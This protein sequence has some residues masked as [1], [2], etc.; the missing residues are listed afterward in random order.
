MTGKMNI[1]KIP[2]RMN[3][4]LNAKA[5]VYF[6]YLENKHGTFS[7]EHRDT[8]LRGYKEGYIAGILDGA[9]NDTERMH[10]ILR[11]ML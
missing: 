7:L 11:R 9:F 6:S 4:W 8:A 3:G 1:S 2:G 5:A 10:S